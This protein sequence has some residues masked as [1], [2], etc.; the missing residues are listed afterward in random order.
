M[1]KFKSFFIEFFLEKKGIIPHLFIEKNSFKLTF[2][3]AIIIRNFKLI[4]PQI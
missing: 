1:S 2:L 3:M 4:K